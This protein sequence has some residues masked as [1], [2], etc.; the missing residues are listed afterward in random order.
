VYPL[1]LNKK[2]FPQEDKELTVKID[3][4]TAPIKPYFF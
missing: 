4:N 3:N 2:G 1:K